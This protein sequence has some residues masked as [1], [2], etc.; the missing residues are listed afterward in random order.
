MAEGFKDTA[1]FAEYSAEDRA[2]ICAFIDAQDAAG[3][4]EEL[5]GTNEVE[6]DYVVEE[7]VVVPVDP[8]SHTLEITPDDANIVYA[9]D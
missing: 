7:V 3:A 4:G 1:E 8:N 9:F 6:V 5:V 2:V